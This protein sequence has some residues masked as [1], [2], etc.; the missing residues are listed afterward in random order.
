[1]KAKQIHEGQGQ[2]TFV[3]VFETDDEVVSELTGFAKDNALSVASLT[4]IGSFS[5]ATLGY[6]DVEKKGFEEIRIEEQVEVLSLVGNI[7]P[8]DNGEP[9]VHAH[10]VVGNREGTTRGGHLFEARV[11]PTLEVVIVD[12][13]GYLQRRRDEET[14][15]LLVRPSVSH[16]RSLG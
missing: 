7:I 4:A 14:G 1:M 11:R 16:W 8:E 13:P 12:S 2:K 15:L 3:L 5:H 9:R 6:F 10:V